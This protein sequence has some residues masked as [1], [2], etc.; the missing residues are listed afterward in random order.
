MSENFHLSEQ[1]PND[2]IGGGG[3]ACSPL[4]NVDAKGPYAVFPA[5]E[6]DSNLSPYVVV[7]A[8]CAELIVQRACG[9]LLVAGERGDPDPDE[10][11]VQI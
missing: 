11:P 6:T 9:E 7:C 2:G 5:T 1:N 3:C 4:K 8:P 10:E